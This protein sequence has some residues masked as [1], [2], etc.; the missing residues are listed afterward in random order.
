MYSRNGNQFFCPDFF[1]RNWPNSTLDGELWIE[2]N[3][4]QKCVSVVKKKTPDET[5]WKK[6]HY[7][8]FDTPG[9]NLPFKDRYQIM[10]EEIPKLNNPYIRVVHNRICTSR[11]DMDQE[12]EKV[13]GLSGEGLMLRN[14]KSFYERKRSKNLLKVKKFLDDEALVYGYLR[15]P[16]GDIKAML[17]R[18]NNG[19]EFKIGGGLTDAER[20]NPPKIGSRITYKY[21]NLSEN[22][23][24]RFPIYQRPYQKL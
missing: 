2:R 14:P 1:T 10:Q 12:L 3:T 23:I 21:Q 17:V 8:V 5:E 15:R 7:L 16:Q 4:F 6:I 13:L 22:G 20:R 11:S 19:K 24:P 9:L 18:L